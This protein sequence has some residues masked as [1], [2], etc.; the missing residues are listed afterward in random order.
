MDF[1]AITEEKITH[2]EDWI[3]NRQMKILFILYSNKASSILVLQ[4]LFELG[5]LDSD[6]KCNTLQK[7][8]MRFPFKNFHTP[9]IN[10]I[11]D[12]LNFFISNIIKIS[13]FRKE[14]SI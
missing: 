10:P 5:P 12:F 6:L 8:I 11:F 7:F 1:Y 9:I 4:L 3:N 2:F 13:S 14:S